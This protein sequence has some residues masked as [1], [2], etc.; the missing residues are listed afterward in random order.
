MYRRVFKTQK[1]GNETSLGDIGLN[2]RTHTSSKVGQDQV[3][4]GVL[5]NVFKIFVMKKAN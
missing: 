3:S 4:G 5:Q 1:S 2:I